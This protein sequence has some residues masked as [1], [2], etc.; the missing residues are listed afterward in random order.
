MDPALPLHWETSSHGTAAASPP[1][2][3]S[4]NGDTPRQ[5]WA[6]GAAGAG[7]LAV[8]AGLALRNPSRGGGVLACPVHAL[9]GWWCP[10]CGLTRGTARLLR[11]DVG[12]AVAMNPLTPLVV[13]VVV[14]AW[15]LAAQRAMGRADGGLRRWATRIAARLTGPAAVAGLLAFGVLRNV[16]GLHWLAPR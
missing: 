11:G 4:A 16:P 1:A 6:V 13:T 9:T 14:I 2:V 8:G 5:R 10:M 7:L 12:G 3:G 15:T